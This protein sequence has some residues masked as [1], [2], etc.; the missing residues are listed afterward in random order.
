MLDGFVPY[1]EDGQGAPADG[2]ATPA[3][4]EVACGVPD[5]AAAQGPERNLK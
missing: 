4:A 2:V 3:A 5:E 1:V